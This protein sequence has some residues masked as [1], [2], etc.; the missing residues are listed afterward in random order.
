MRTVVVAGAIANKPGNGGEAWVR[1][2]WVRGLAALGFGVRFIEVIDDRLCRDGD[3]RPCELRNSVARCWFDAVIARFA[4]TASAALLCGDEVHGA[5]PCE[6]LR[7]ADEAD[8]LI[9]ISGHLGSAHDAS[10]LFSRFANT[11]YV[12]LDPGYTQVW[13]M[14]GQGD[15]RLDG[16]SR[17]ATVG[18]LVG[19]PDCAVPDAGFE[20]L[21]VPP[22]FVL[23]DWPCAPAPERKA[24]TTVSTWRNR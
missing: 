9:D 5:T 15:T 2:S 16:H 4:M 22:F 17:H 7:W 23:A 20:W 21:H 8:L 24:L 12:D 11:L 18:L 1:M 6:L 13:H 10:S 19:E 3:G 14:Q